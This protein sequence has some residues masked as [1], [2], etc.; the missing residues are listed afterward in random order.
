[1][2]FFKIQNFGLLNILPLATIILWQWVILECVVISHTV[3]SLSDTAL[4]WCACVISCE[5]QNNVT[6]GIEAAA[7]GCA[8]SNTL[9]AERVSST[10]KGKWLVLHSLATGGSQRGWL[11]LLYWGSTDRLYWRQLPSER[12]R[13]SRVLLVKIPLWLS[14]SVYILKIK[15]HKIL[16]V[17]LN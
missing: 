4:E 3:F 14:A 2:L 16:L 13:A 8:F 17:A 12:E 1:M 6:V 15:P 9:N 10:E 5:V 11:A 7:P